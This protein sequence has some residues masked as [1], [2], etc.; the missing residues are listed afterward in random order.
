MN[1]LELINYFET[2]INKGLPIDFPEF[3]DID[4]IQA[5]KIS[6]KFAK[7]GLI[8]LPKREMQFFEWLKYQ[9]YPV[10]EDLWG[11]DG[12]EPYIVGL[13][14]LPLLVDKLRG[15]PICDLVECDNYYFTEECIIEEEGKL[16]RESSQNR[17]ISGV[18]LTIEQAFVVEFCAAPID[19]W[20]FCYRYSVD[21]A[22]MKHTIL[23]M[24]E[25][26]LLLHVKN[27]EQLAGLIKI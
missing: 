25:E 22:K 5:I 27:R 20:H 6:E 8:R 3:L 15:F 23:Q 11:G 21:I 14:F 17:F 7:R 18:K 19:I 10:W 1:D 12:E 4:P 2:E 24:A 13:S 9:D 26:K 16:F